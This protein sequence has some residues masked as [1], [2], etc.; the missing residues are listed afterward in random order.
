MDRV[1]GRSLKMIGK[2]G[3]LACSFEDPFEKM[4]RLP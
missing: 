1:A 4:S 2:E 3:K